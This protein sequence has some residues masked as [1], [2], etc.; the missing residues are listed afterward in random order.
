M[1]SKS[2]DKCPYRRHT[3]ERHRQKKRGH[4]TTA[5]VG[6]TLLQTRETRTEATAKSW[7]RQERFSSGAFKEYSFIN[8]LILDF[9]P[10]NYERINLLF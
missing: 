4:V 7:K 1:G 6:V 2:N 5:E 8:T 10:Q 3:D 9:C